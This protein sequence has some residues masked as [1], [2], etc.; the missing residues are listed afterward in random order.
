MN[1]VTRP[2]TTIGA[3]E[4]KTRL[5]ELLDRVEKGE[6]L[7]ITR[8]G[9]AIARLVPEGSVDVAAARAALERVFARA[10]AIAARTGMF[11]HEEIIEMRDEGRNRLDRP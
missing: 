9:T 2:V 6:E 3:Y 4:A 10:D 8:H 7:V 5:S 1:V 11:T